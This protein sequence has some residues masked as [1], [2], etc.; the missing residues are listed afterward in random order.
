MQRIGEHS[1]IAHSLRVLSELDDTP[2]V[3]RVTGV[4][5][6]TVEA[7]GPRADVGELVEIRQEGRLPTLA[8]VIGF[9]GS[10]L[11]LMPLE[12]LSGTSAG[13]MV[14]SYG[15]PLQTPVGHALLGRVLDGLGRPI[16]GEGPLLCDHYRPVHGEPPHPLQRKTIE[17]PLPL[18]VKAIDGLATCGKGQRLGIFAGS[19]VGK[20]TLLG[21]LARGARSDV[22]VIAL[23]G[24]RG[25]EVREFIER[26][27]GETGRARSVVIVA[28]ADQPAMLRLKGAFLATSIAEYFRDLGL[29]VLLM[30]DSVTRFAIA[31]RE[32]GLSAGEPPATKGYTPSVFAL[33]PRLLERAGSSEKGT[34]TGLYTVL[35]DG[36]DMNDPIADS[37][38]SILDG[39]ITLSRSLAERGHYPAIDVLSSVSRTMMHIVSKEHQRA[40]ERL[41][42]LIASYRQAEDLINIGAY[43]KGNNPIVDE[44]IEKLHAINQFLRQGVEEYGP[45]D[46]TVRQMMAIVGES[47]RDETG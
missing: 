30:M 8:E 27:L 18:G 9:R 5:G 17:E 40:A 15:L 36:D 4:V 32:V 47:I 34:I 31:Q 3:G 11:L 22:N 29:D 25:R 13:A 12:E 33:L 45:F 38:R 20:S 39:H 2:R 42:E 28:T 6:L 46:D 10:K 37:V 19:G 43:V 41:K 26:D 14:R 24:E 16:D 23:I 21:M 1:I 7:E 35:V 44:S